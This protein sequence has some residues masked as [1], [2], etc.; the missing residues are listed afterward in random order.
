MKAQLLTVLSLATFTLQAQ[1]TVTH[2]WIATL[3]DT[4]FL[5]EDT[6][7]GTTLNLGSAAGNQTWDFT[8]L[9][10][11]DPDGA[12][13]EDP[14][15]APLSSNFP[16]ADF[17]IYDDEDDSYIFFEQDS[18]YLDLVGFVES[19]SN[20]D[21]VLPEFELAFRFM[22]FPA[23]MGTTFSSQNGVGTQTQHIGVDPDSLGPHP[24]IDSIRSKF[25]FI[26]DNEID[27]WGDL[28][29]PNGTFL[30]IRQRAQQIVK[31]SSDCFIN[32]SWQPFTPLMLTFLDSV[33]YDSSDVSYRWWSDNPAADFM[34]AEVS[35]D[36][37][38]NPDS[39]VTFSN[40][41]PGWYVGI[42]DPAQ[43]GFE[44]Y[45]NPTVERVTVETTYDRNWSMLLYDVEGKL[46]MQETATQSRHDL[47]VTGMEAGVY[48]MQITDD[49]GQ[50]LRLEKL[51]VIH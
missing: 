18:T 38:G 4:V 22:Q 44:I 16:T 12:I 19:D 11:H 45:P 7:N 39:T 47:N 42:N 5:S 51:Q 8:A 37:A 41:E 46:V 27:A 35:V 32:G 21:P 3:G 1:I 13:L 31:I 15:T 14:S 28:Q 23:T 43:V 10:E 36:S 48:L 50:L 2:E 30:S 29:L 33:S 49:N 24:T 9:V 26:I 34:I 40:Q 6:V 17:V 25:F 20:G